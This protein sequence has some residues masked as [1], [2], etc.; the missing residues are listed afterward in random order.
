MRYSD[1]LRKLKQKTKRMYDKDSE[2]INAMISIIIML[3][4]LTWFC[5]LFMTA[6]TYN[7]SMIHSV[8][9]TDTMDTEQT[10]DPDISPNLTI[11]IK[12]I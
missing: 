3:S 1:H 7:I 2:K 5:L 4:V 6:C 12:P 8:G 9:S 10:A 11:P